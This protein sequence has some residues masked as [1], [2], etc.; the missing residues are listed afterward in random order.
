[1]TIDSGNTKVFVNCGR[2]KSAIS[3][4][5]FVPTEVFIAEF[6]P[7][8]NVR[9]NF[10]IKNNMTRIIFWKKPLFVFLLVM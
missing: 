9:M 4:P 1:M 6:L 5:V 8:E 3:T 10:L 2:D 7:E